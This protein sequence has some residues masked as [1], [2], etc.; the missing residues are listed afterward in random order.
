MTNR[1]TNKQINN[2]FAATG[3]LTLALL[4]TI[5]F[6][7]LLYIIS[8]VTHGN[9]PAVVQATPTAVTPRMVELV[10]TPNTKKLEDGTPPRPTV[11]KSVETPVSNSNLSPKGDLFH[12]RVQM[13]DWFNKES[14]WMI[15]EPGVILDDTAAWTIP[16]TK[17]TWYANVPEGGFTYFSMGEGKISVAGVDIVMPGAKGLNYLVL[18][19]GRIDDGIVDS[20]LNLTA[21]VSDFVPG[22][23]IWSIMPPGA[24]VSK[25][26]FR[27]QL[28]FSTTTGGTNCGATGCSTVHIILLD[29][30]SRTL[31]K[32]E[33]KAADIDTW[34]LLNS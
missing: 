12:S 19:R 10:P 29:V 3:A 16:S 21:E 25:N 34:A 23:A 32:F 2:V 15:A 1:R 4:A 13:T 18:I 30:D 5:G 17:E 24:Y 33:A 14:A 11:S 27:Q 20:D 22:H 7:A 28:V 6:F 8:S 31:Q 26:W 9:K